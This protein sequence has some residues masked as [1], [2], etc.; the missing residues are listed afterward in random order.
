VVSPREKGWKMKITIFFL[1]TVFTFGSGFDTDWVKLRSDVPKNVKF[2]N[3]IEKV[4]FQNHIKKITK[5]SPLVTVLRPTEVR[6][7]ECKEREDGMCFAYKAKV[8]KVLKGKYDKSY[9]T[10]VNNSGF[11]SGISF[12]NKI[13][14]L[15]KE[16]KDEDINEKVHYSPEF[17]EYEA[18]QDIIDCFKK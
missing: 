16:Y 6:I 18:R 14:L 15:S 7:F 12:S 1:M 11:T 17:F 3:S 2:E 4:R 9:I 5:E 8:I 10:F 13:Y